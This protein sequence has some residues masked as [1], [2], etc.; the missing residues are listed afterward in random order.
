MEVL[1]SSAVVAVGMTA[2]ASLSGTLMIQ[3]ELGWRVAVVRNY[4]ENMARVWQLGIDQRQVMSLMP[5][6][7][8]NI[9]LNQIINGTPFIVQTGTTTPAGLGTMQV[10]TVTAS[11]NIS[12]NIKVETQ[13]A[14]LTLSVYRPSLPNSLRPVVP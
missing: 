5:S 13:G 8:D 14:P 10:A 3:E 9:T 11:V 12:Q 1:A 4:Q 6:Q 2:M 7:T